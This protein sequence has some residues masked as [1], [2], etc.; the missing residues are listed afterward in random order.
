MRGV[1]LYDVDI[2]GEIL[3]VTINGVDV[4][5]LIEAELDRRDPERATALRPTDPEGFREAWDVNE[6]RWGRRSSRPGAGLSVL[7]EQVDGEWSFIETL[8]HLAFATEPGS[9][10]AI[11]GDP[12][13]VAPRRLPWDEMPDTP[14]VPRDREV[15]PSLTSARAAA[16]PDG[17]RPGV[18]RAL[19]SGVLAGQLTPVEGRGGRAAGYPVRECHPHR[20]STRSTTTGSSPSA[21]AVI[22]WGGPGHA[23]GGPGHAA[24]GPTGLTP[25]VC[26]GGAH[27]P[28]EQCDARRPQAP[29]PRYLPRRPWRKLLCPGHTGLKIAQRAQPRAPPPHFLFWMG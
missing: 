13:A 9:G 17:D 27:E 28:T 2:S 16:R 8:R 4:A 14:G 21:T 26:L 18:P 22:E 24:G 3:N 11:H 29:G 1:D 7:H 23:L 5:P 19:T 25:R 12:G 15:P 6:R 10:R 20:S